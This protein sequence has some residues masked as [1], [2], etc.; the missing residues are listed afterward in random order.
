MKRKDYTDLKGKTVAELIKL[1]SVKRTDAIKKKMQS[2]AGKEKNLKAY[3]NLRV[4]I[5]KILTLVR[6]KEI[7]EEMQSK[8]VKNQD[9]K[10]KA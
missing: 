2:L 8:E 10:E 4:E 5:A 7:L 6:E 3:R 1:A 9:G